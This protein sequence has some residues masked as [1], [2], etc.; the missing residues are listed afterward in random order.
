MPRGGK[1]SGKPGASYTNRTDLNKPSLAAPPKTYGDAAASA[2]AQQA[3][4]LPQAGPPGG[5]AAGAGMQ[6]PAGPLPGE[7]QFGRGS[8]RPMEPLTAGMNVGPGPGA[9]AT[10]P[11]VDPVVENLRAAARAFPN[12]AIFDLLERL[13]K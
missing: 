8:D 11:T 10:M 3:V 12:Q 4:P 5:P 9:S 7:L 6:P 2:R 13:E 1:R